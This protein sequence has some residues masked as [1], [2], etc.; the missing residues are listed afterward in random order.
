MQCLLSEPRFLTNEGNLVESP[1]GSGSGSFA[2]SKI[3]CETEPST[4]TTSAVSLDS[5]TMAV[6]SGYADAVLFAF[7]FVLVYIGFVVVT[8]LFR[9][10]T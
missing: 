7:V 2:Y 9:R 10:G 1:T 4:A 3:V 8:T 6:L 5:A